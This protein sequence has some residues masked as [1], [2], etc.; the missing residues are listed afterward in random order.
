MISFYSGAGTLAG[1]A[2]FIR[3]QS[4]TRVLA[5]VHVAAHG[6]AAAGC[7]GFGKDFVVKFE[8]F[9]KNVNYTFCVTHNGND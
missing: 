5:F 4:K 8:N 6:L 7:A 9:Y 3:D 2:H 1:L